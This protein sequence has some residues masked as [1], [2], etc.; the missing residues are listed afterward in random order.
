VGGKKVLEGQ[1]T[2]AG[3]QLPAFGGGQT[4]AQPEGSLGGQAGFEPGHTG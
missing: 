4:H 1:E 3:E 2:V